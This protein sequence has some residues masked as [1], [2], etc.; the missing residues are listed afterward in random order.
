M[1]VVSGPSLCQ[2]PLDI[3]GG[4]GGGLGEA[5]LTRILCKPYLQSRSSLLLIVDTLQLIP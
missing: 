4:L 2:P 5:L 3:R 1:R